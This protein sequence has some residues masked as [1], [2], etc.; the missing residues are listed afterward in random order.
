MG[1]NL[2]RSWI[3]DYPILAFTENVSTLSVPEPT[4]TALLALGLLG[5]GPGCARRCLG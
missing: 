2:P 4:T 3:R 5:A 1:E